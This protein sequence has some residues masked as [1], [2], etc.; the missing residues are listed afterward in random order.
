MSKLS[1]TP[2]CDPWF[3]H[4]PSF[5]Q[6]LVGMCKDTLFSRMV[7][8]GTR[9]IGKTYFFL[10][11]L[12][13]ELLKNGILPIYINMWGNKSAPHAEFIQQLSSVLHEIKNE[14]MV[15]RLLNSEIQKF[16]IG[17]QIGKVE[18]EFT[19]K[20]ASDN[21][22]KD[23]KAMIDDVVNGAGNKKVVFILDEFQH[24]STSSAF[25]NFLYALRTVF[26]VYG[27]RI[28]VIFTGS[29]RT[30]MRAAFE[31]DQV[32]FYQS[33]Q[34]KEF[35]VIDDGFIDH[36]VSR[37]HEVYGM[38]VNRLELLDFWH[39]IDHSPHWII[40]LMREL[41]SNQWSLSRAIAFIREAIKTEE[42]H[43][44]I[45]NGLTSTDKAVLLLLH[46]GKGIYSESSQAFIKRVG[47]RATKG[48]AQSSERKLVSKSIVSVLPNKRVIVE[49]YGLVDAVWDDIGIPKKKFD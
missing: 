43:N 29:S 8:L 39:E 24:L 15:K 22:I 27:A 1:Y 46:A 20:S 3:Y 16:A 13:P 34:V 26:D 12:S 21:E 41:I 4:R 35:P 2:Y 10:N 9:R 17:N 32:P 36:C 45:I 7:Y 44:E 18:V 30:G 33:A 48:S 14:G 23:I 11:D 28:T 42:S 25:D 38:D 40:N 47:G 37:L 49:Y 6:H 31:D 5:A 19:A